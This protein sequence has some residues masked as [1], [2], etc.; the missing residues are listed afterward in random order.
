MEF[1]FQFFLA[2]AISVLTAL[3]AIISVQC[4]NMKGVLAGQIA[5]NLFTAL[6]YILLDGMTGAGLCLIAIVHTVA[7][8]VYRNLEINPPLWLTAIFMMLYLGCSVYY[9]KTFFDVFSTL[10]SVC[11]V[12]AMS[13]EK[14]ERMRIF[15]SINLSSWIIYDVATMAYVNV[16]VHFSVLVSTVLAMIRYRKK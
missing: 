1:T 13:Q 11:F 10:A 7:L 14:P 5:A 12:I 9:F 15:T 3:S 2:Q 8:F 6:T 16:I 4:K